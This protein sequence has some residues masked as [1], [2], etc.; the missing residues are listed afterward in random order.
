M[1]PWKNCNNGM[2]MSKIKTLF[3]PIGAGSPLV[4]RLPNS[5]GDTDIKSLT[6]LNITLSKKMIKVGGER[7]PNSHGNTESKSLALLNISLPKKTKFWLN[8]PTL[9][10]LSSRSI[11]R[12]LPSKN[13]TDGGQ[14]WPLRAPNSHGNIDVTSLQSSTILVAGE[15]FIKI[16][17]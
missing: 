17:I 11:L 2:R 12:L 3:K 5:H 15:R 6:L 7:L 14:E 9:I 16:L 10:N 4:R 1:L 13:S 8:A